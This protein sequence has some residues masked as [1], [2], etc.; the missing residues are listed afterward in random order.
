[1]ATNGT[2]MQGSR[3]VKQLV[4][5]IALALALPSGLA[6]AD[7]GKQGARTADELTAMSF[8][9]LASISVSSVSLLE[10]TILDAASS[11][12]TVDSN[13]W[14]RRG[15]RRMLDAIEFQPGIMVLPHT[16]GNEVLAIRGYARSTSYAG[17]ATSWDGVPLNDLFRSGPQFN[18][19]SINLGALSQVQLIQ[20][21]GS[22]LYGS[23]A[24]H[25][26]VAL[27][28][29]ESDQDMTL[30]DGKV[31]SNS[32]AETALQS[33]AR[34]GDTRWSLAL[35]ANGQGDQERRASY[36][37]PTTGAAVSTLRA[38]RYQAQTGSLKFA[39]ESK[40]SLSWYGGLYFHHYDADQ[41]QGLGTRLSGE[42]DL[43]WLNTMFWMAQAGLK[44]KLDGGGS[45][46]AKVYGWWVENDLESNLLVSGSPAHRDLLA[47]Q[48]RSGVQAIYRDSWPAGR[49][50]MALALG[51]EWLAVQGAKSVVTSPQGAQLSSTVN[52]AQ[53][54]RRDVN[55]ATLEMNTRFGD[56]WRL[57]Y[58]GRLDDYSDF[59]SHASPRVGL[60]FQS[61][62]GDAIKLLVGQAFRAPN[63]VEIGGATNSVLGNPDIKPEVIDSYEL[64]AMRRTASYLVQATLFRTLWHDGISAVLVPSAGLT[65]YQ[66]VGRNDAKGLSASWQYRTGGWL[67]DAS[68]AFVSSRNA[69]TG[70]AYS[71]FPRWM[72]D[73]GISHTLDDPSMQFGVNQRFMSQVDDIATTEG[74]K[75]TPLPRFLRTDLSFN[76]DFS[77]QSS[78]IFQVRNLFNRNNVLPSPPA[79]LGGIP[80]ERLSFSVA[81]RRRF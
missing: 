35:A 18:L 58:G 77:G 4:Q 39:S 14:R 8:E 52:R 20:G 81:L 69:I 17:V 25:G 75:V 59:G 44:Q 60:I 72:A 71:I 15:G 9:E 70:A 49:T 73:V 56:Q 40:A 54:A 50:E 31:A 11:V 6:W 65:Q 24:F 64:V 27:R 33:S 30:V 1:M 2:G 21:P 10:A 45:L 16:S 66:N 28:G 76:K 12:A 48:T 32:Y 53:G 19:P 67:V 42:Q 34:I 22:A 62:S 78:A 23:D 51:R 47:M 7:A 57:V 74:F 26:M 80:Q 13:D 68:G 63:A 61:Q 36:V 29:F 41:F 37:Q 38:N 46:E 3:K 43:G 55:S 5:S 79:S